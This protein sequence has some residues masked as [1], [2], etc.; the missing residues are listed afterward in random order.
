M[1][2]KIDIQKDVKWK[3]PLANFS[4][5][6]FDGSSKGNLD[7][8]SSNCII[9]DHNRALIVEKVV[10][11]PIGTNKIAMAN[12]LLKGIQLAIELQI[13]NMYIQ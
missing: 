6:N 13:K 3:P 8:S 7:P 5:L 11:L 12:A 1:T 10:K 2:N 9:H 4:K